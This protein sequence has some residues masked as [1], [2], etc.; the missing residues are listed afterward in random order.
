MKPKVWLKPF[1]YLLQIVGGIGFLFLTAQRISHGLPGSG[2]EIA[3]DVA[4]ISIFIT[5]AMVVGVTKWLQDIEDRLNKTTS[6]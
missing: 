3:L 4:N 5:G 2:A 1:G 6:P